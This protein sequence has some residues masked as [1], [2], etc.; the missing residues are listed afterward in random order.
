MDGL[1]KFIHFVSLDVEGLELD[2]LLAWPFKTVQVGA[3][4]IEHNYEDEKRRRVIALM[5]EN[6]YLRH[7][8]ENAGVDDYFVKSDYWR[9][10]MSMKPWRTHPHGTF[11]C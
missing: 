9:P 8:V 7:E 2:I 1:P 10:H 11:G 3:W 6:G 5:A 4:V